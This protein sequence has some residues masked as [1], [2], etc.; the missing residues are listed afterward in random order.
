MSVHPASNTSGVVVAAS[1]PTVWARVYSIVSAVLGV[2]LLAQFLFAGLAVFTI[3]D[4]S[5]SGTAAARSLSD[6]DTFWGLH[7]FNA[8]LIALAILVLVGMAFAARKPRR[9]TLLTALFVPLYI[10]Q[11]VLAFTP[12]AP[13][14][15]VHVLNALVILALAG[16]VVRSNW[17]FGR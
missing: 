7:F 8:L 13:V 4:E 3:M 6:A 10:L 5:G 2:L 9:T 15:A 16:Y 17:A 14:S 12:L 11:A 1:R